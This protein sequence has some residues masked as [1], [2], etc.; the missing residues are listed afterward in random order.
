MD[1]DALNRDDIPFPLKVTVTPDVDAEGVVH[2]PFTEAQL[3]LLMARNGWSTDP[4][5]GKAVLTPGGAEIFNPLPM[6]P[7]VGYVQEPTV[8]DRLNQLLDSRA[9][10]AQLYDNDVIEETLE[11]AED[12][13][14]IED[15]EDYVPRSI[16]EIQLLPEVPALKRPAESPAPAPVGES[17]PDE[18]GDGPRPDPVV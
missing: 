1:H 6:A 16:Y 5:T 18:P 12:F 9:R 14:G 3:R 8:M 11:E 10:A 2:E 17:V 15:P 7:P 13:D 4:G